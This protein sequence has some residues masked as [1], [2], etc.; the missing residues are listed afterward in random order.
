MARVDRDIDTIIAFCKTFQ[1]KYIDAMTQH[2]A[3]M[4]KLATEI[5]GT[6][7]GTPFASNS[8]MAVMNVAKKMQTALYDGEARI[9]ELERNAQNDRARGEEFER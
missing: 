1:S 9:R 2:A 3:N 5:N 4:Q 8:Q 7:N 6:L